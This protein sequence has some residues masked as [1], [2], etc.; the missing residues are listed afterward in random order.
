MIEI[1]VLQAFAHEARG[2]NPAALA[3]LEHA[4]A[5]AEP[6]GYVRVFVDEGMP[7][8]Q[9]LSEA[10]AHGIMPDYAARLSAAFEAEEQK[11]EDE[12]HR[13]PTESV[14]EPLSQRELEVLRLVGQGLSNRQI[15]ERL[16]LA[17]STV[18][19]HN[20]IIFSKLMVQNRTGAVAR[21]RELGLL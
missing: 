2:D 9:L 14:V 16:F 7:M 15:S 6:E 12:S 4:L 19:G 13:F 17:L 5:L 11:S 10:A 8:S 3:P 21:A 1:L 18:K 20:R